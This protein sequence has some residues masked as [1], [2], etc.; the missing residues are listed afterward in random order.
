M[1]KRSA[2][3]IALIFGLLGPLSLWAVEFDNDG[4]DVEVVKVTDLQ[5]LGQE[6]LEHNVPIVMMLSADG[7]SWCIKLEEEHFKPMLRSG[8]YEG[9]VLIRQFKIDDVFKVR[10]FD[11]KMISPDEIN[12]RYGAFVTPTV[13]Y[14]DGYGRELAKKM[15]G[16]STG[17]YYGSYVDMAIDESLD[18]L[19]RNTPLRAKLA[20][21]TPQ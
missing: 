7:C 8:D 1:I 11:G 14:L 4:A 18:M 15:V 10:D 16:L 3:K 17:H 12:T 9:K 6:S 13:I 20:R 5:K 2:L 19:R 21:L